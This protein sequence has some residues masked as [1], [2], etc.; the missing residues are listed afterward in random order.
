MDVGAKEIADERSPDPLPSPPPFRGENNPF[1]DVRRKSISERKAG[2]SEGGISRIASNSKVY[3]KAVTNRL[4]IAFLRPVFI[5]VREIGD[6]KRKIS[7][8]LEKD[9]LIARGDRVD[10]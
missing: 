6:D 7:G 8:F 3:R 2:V 10:L 9:G 5:E 1:V 4:L